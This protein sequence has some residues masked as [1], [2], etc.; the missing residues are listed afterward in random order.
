MNMLILDEGLR[1]KP[2]RCTAGKLTIGVGRNLDDVGISGEEALYLLKHDI[3]RAERACAEAFDFWPTL[4]GAR[5]MVLVN[6][7]FNLGIN[8]LL[9]FQRTLDAVRYGDY[10]LAAQRMIDSKWA[11]Q[12]GARADRLAKI[13][14]TGNLED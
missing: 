3:D 12:V 4:P 5:K 11:K 9:K 14:E 10:A 13:M 1:L 8:G 2:Y 7:A 6:M